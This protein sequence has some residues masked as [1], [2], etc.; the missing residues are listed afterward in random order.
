MLATLTSYGKPL[1]TVSHV[2]VVL[3]LLI[4]FFSRIHPQD[5]LPNEL[6]KMDWKRKNDRF[7]I[8]G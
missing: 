5:V 4:I 7:R 2:P 8:V 3:L 1:D 6:R